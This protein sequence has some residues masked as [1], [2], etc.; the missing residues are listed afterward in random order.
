MAS[1]VR[2]IN[3]ILFFVVGC[4]LGTLPNGVPGLIP[5]I[6]DRFH[7]LFYDSPHTWVQNHWNLVR[8]QQNP[9][10][11][12]IIQEIISE[13]KPDIIIEAG[14]YYGGSALMWAT[15]LEQ[16]NPQGKIYTI[17]I[18]DHTA[19]AK[20]RSI[21]QNKVEFILASSTDKAVVERLANIA[22]DKRVLVILDS[23]HSKNHVLA[24]LNLYAAM[25][26]K[27]SYIIV[28]DTNVNGHPAYSDFGPGPM[29]AVHEFLST[30]KD[31]QIDKSRERLLFTMYPNGY[32][33]KIAD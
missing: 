25:V 22:K 21:W 31:F 15:I 24:E 11:A 8:A 30:N 6:T 4:V 2:Y 1:L 3:Y 29:E 19:E 33:K 18:E 7:V 27:G 23:D 16:V 10:D 5:S 14:T 13:T 26:N 20:L 9:N 17:D 28:Q 32:L 12:W